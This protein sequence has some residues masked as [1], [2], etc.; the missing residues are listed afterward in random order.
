MKR[1][2]N[3]LILTIMVLVGLIIATPKVDA[4]TAPASFTMSREGNYLLHGYN[5]IKG[6]NLDFYIQRTTDGKYV[7]C[8]ERGDKF[9]KVLETYYKK[10]EMDAGL[11]YILENGYPNV[12]F[13]GNKDEDYWI[14]QTAVWYYLEQDST[15]W[16]HFDF[17]KGTYRGTYD[18]D[19]V[20]INKLITGAKTATTKQFSLTPNRTSDALTLTNDSTYYVSSRLSVEGSGLN[21]ISLALTSAPVGTFIVNAS[22]TKVTTVKSGESFYVKVPAYNINSSTTVNLK[23]TGTGTSNKVYRYDPS[24]PATQS[25]VALYGEPVSLSSNINLNLN[26]KKP[27]NPVVDI[28]KVDAS[29]RNNLKGA[30]LV[31]RDLNGNIIDKW[32]TNGSVHRITDIALGTYTIEEISAPAGYKLNTDKIKFTLTETNYTKSVEF[33]NYKKD[34]TVVKIMKIDS[35]TKNPLSGAEL[36]LKDRN[37]NVIDRWISTT[38]YHTIEGLKEDEIYYLSEISAPN[39][40]EINSRTEEI[41]VYSDGKTATYTFENTPKLPDNPQTGIEDFI[42]P[43]IITIVGGGFG[44]MLL[45]KRSPMRQF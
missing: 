40:Y 28:Y 41:I 15:L 26:Y 35:N 44:M 31:V 4:A 13:T 25:V 39:G 34:I 1:A 23:V 33:E 27:I 42:L 16:R 7:Y 11:A 32:T 36:V 5:Y 38:D 18:Q 9:T 12:S 43:A 21:T 17:A 3:L 10:G 8:I 29:S 2:K 37:G 6:I 30:V 45:K 22:G 24:N 14:T 19:V 20:Y